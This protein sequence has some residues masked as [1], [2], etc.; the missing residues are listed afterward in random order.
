MIQTFP[1]SRGEARTG[2]L[3]PDSAHGTTPASAA[4]SGF[5]VVEV[6]SGPDGRISLADLESKLSSRVA[7]LMLTN[8]NTL[9]LFER[10]ILDIAELVDNTG[11]MLFYDGANLNSFLGFGPPG[12]LMLCH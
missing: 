5:Q 2:V 10:D 1:R 8:P 12:V 9:G 7:A 11:A 3:V 6:A 4:L